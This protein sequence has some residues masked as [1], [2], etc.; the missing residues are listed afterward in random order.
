M[1]LIA[2]GGADAELLAEIGNLQVLA[3][4]AGTAIRHYRDALSR[5]PNLVA[6][7]RGLAY[8]LQVAGQAAASLD[9]YRALVDS[10][11][12][13]A[14]AQID[15]GLA[16]LKAGDAEAA[17]E[18]LRRGVVL[19]PKNMTARAALGKLLQ[20]RV[21]QWHFLMLGD[22]T[23]NAT[24]DAA[25]RRAVNPGA[26]VLDIGTGSGLLAMMAARAGAGHV[27]ACE[28][29][30][31][32]AEKAREIVRSNGLGDRI[33][34]IP[35]RS[36]ELR[37]GLDLPR[38]VDVLVSEIVDEVLLGE[39]IV[40]TLAHALTELVMENA[41]VVPRA[42]VIHAM[43]VESAMLHH[44]GHVRHAAGFDVSA[45]NEFSRFSCRAVDLRD[46]EYRPLS[47]PAKRSASTE[48][49]RPSCP[50][51]RRSSLPSRSA[52]PATPW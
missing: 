50:R 17:I 18:A 20:A 24:Y 45:F 1:P 6:A 52:A 49:A 12:Q 7:R 41:A 16:L 5:A 9:A 46:V 22:A 44:R 29:E 19:D 31:L 47:A 36:L 40:G 28:A 15:F 39:R 21:P 23:R 27:F 33:T 30:P 37:I 25:I 2:A 11:P 14:Q 34:I 48:P 42:G 13:D 32:L 26:V 35:K 3:G 38:K 8:A 51:A 43:L 4:D 10:A